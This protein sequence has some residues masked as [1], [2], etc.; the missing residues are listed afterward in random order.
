MSERIGNFQYKEVTFAL[1]VI[2]VILGSDELQLKN[3]VLNRNSKNLFNFNLDTYVLPFT[4]FTCVL[5]ALQN[6]VIKIN[7]VKY[8]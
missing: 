1:S 2:A 3:S 6:I 4:S 8:D 7:R 5:F